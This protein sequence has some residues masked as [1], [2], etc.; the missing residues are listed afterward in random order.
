[1]TTEQ[2]AADIRS[3]GITVTS[4]PPVDMSAPLAKHLE[5]LGYRKLEAAK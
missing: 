2:F 4:G 1:M 5:D 3:L